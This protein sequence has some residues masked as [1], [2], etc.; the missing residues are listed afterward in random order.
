MNFAPIAAVS[1]ILGAVAPAMAAVETTIYSWENTHHNFRVG[2]GVADPFVAVQ[3]TDAWGVT[4]GTYSGE[5]ATAA[6]TNFIRGAWSADLADALQGNSVAKVDFA[7]KNPSTT[8]TQNVTFSIIVWGR[9]ADGSGSFSVELPSLE[10]TR[11]QKGTASIDYGALNPLL[12]TG[13]DEARLEF[14]VTRQGGFTGSYYFDN[15]RVEVVPEPAS[16]ALAGLGGALMLV[17]RRR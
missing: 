8:I 17:R 16:L 4:D 12:T 11:A 3:N 1:L 9:N 7:V 13:V 15:F 2:Q 6:T 14:R 5:A 10:R